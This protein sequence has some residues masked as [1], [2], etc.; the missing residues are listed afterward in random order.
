MNAKYSEVKE[1]DV[2]EVIGFDCMQGLKTIEMSPFGL[3]VTC[4]AGRHYLNGQI[5]DEDGDSLVGIFKASCP[6]S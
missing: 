5:D 6:A 2:V 4:S 3:H 1:G